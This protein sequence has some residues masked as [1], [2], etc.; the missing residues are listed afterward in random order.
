MKSPA[1]TST[2]AP[3]KTNMAVM[4][5]VRDGKNRPLETRM[6]DQ[7]ID[8]LSLGSTQVVIGMSRRCFSAPLFIDQAHTVVFLNAEE[9]PVETLHVLC[10]V[11][12]PKSPQDPYDLYAVCAGKPYSF[13]A[14]LFCNALKSLAKPTES[15]IMINAQQP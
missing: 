3:L 1:S 13:T 14:G 7:P 4:L 6:F 10:A 9:R 11:D 15:T 2:P 12:G 8:I 5:Q